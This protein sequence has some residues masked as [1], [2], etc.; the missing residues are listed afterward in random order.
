MAPADGRVLPARPRISAGGPSEDCV[1]ERA[2]EGVGPGN[3][4][5]HQ[6]AQP[7]HDRASPQAL[8]S[9]GSVGSDSANAGVQ[10]VNLQYCEWAEDLDD[11]QRRFGVRVHHFEDL[12]V[13][14]ALDDVANYL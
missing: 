4:G 7:H 13:K 8:C 9:S 14:D 3:E 11:A 1:L 6:L 12:N 2:A 5:R 10:F